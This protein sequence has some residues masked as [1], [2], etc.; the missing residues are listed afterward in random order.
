MSSKTFHPTCLVLLLC[1][2]CTLGELIATIQGYTSPATEII[3][4][5]LLFIFLGF[6]GALALVQSKCTFVVSWKI[7]KAPLIKY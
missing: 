6:V 2:N 3:K 7:S 1:V 5:N 4:D